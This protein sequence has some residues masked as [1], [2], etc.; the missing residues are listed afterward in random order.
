MDVLADVL[1][2]VRLK[3]RIFARYEMTAPWGMKIK[4]C[5][6]PLFYA[7]SRGGG[8]LSV[9][10]TKLSL[11]AG[12]FVFLPPG[13]AFDI[14]DRPSSRAIPIERIY[15]TRGGRCGGILR[16]GGGSGAPTTLIAGSVHLEGSEL[17]PVA[18]CIPPVLHVTGDR[19]GS[20]RWLDA[21]MQFVASEMETE[22]PGYETV[23]ERLADVL[24]VQALRT[25]MTTPSSA[26]NGWLRALVD[27]RIG[28]ALRSVHERP[29][30]EWTL[31]SLAKAASMSRSVFAARFKELVGSAPLEYVTR[32]RMHLASERLRGG[33]D[34][35]GQVARDVGY[36]TESA[37][38][39]AF[40]REVG[41]TPGAFRRSARAAP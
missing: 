7:V 40:K 31:E 14:R 30:D 39:K 28:Q 36:D 25:H 18:T 32:W 4:T 2:H 34:G 23:V 5:D 13:A 15:A 20:A 16:F 22:L 21:T 38:G 11:A 17:S 6:H 12:D 33:T 9:G 19:A 10:G 41:T 24:F 27:P 8:T 37:F 26:N 1:R 35:I 3:S 29:G